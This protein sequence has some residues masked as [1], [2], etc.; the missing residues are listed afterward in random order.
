MSDDNTKEMTEQEKQDYRVKRLKF[1]MSTYGCDNE[2][3]CKFIEYRQEGYTT[4]QAALA[5]GL[6]DPNG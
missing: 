2:T 5:L 4:F 3:A 1:I 6:T